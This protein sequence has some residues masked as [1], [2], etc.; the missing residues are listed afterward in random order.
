VWWGEAEHPHAEPAELDVQVGAGGQL[1]DTPAPLGEDLAAL[2]GIAAEADRAA[3]MVEHDRGLGKGAR[4]ID[5]LAGAGC[6]TSTRR[7]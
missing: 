6:D 5:E 1:A 4:Q 3:D 7:S 2:A